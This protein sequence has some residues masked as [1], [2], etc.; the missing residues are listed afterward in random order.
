[1][2]K[3]YQIEHYFPRNF[4]LPCDKRLTLY[5]PRPSLPTFSLMFI[6]PFNFKSQERKLFVILTVPSNAVFYTFSSVNLV[7]IS[8]SNLF[9]PLGIAS[10]K[11]PAIN[12][13]ISTFRI[14]HIVNLTLEILKFLHFLTFLR[15]N[16][17][18]SWYDN[19]DHFTDSIILHTTTIFGLLASILWSYCLLKF[20]HTLELMLERFVCSV[21]PIHTTQ[22]PV[23][24]YS[25][26]TQVCFTH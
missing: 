3:S 5:N 15:V 9:R 26:F 8:W 4:L 11:A 17:A 1:M 20:Q 25:F 12:R 24:Q 19:I 16:S 7:P 14:A 13:I 18:I 2:E 6:T 21:Q 22:F 10:G 23:N